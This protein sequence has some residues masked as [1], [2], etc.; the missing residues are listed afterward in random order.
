MDIKKA[1][2]KTWRHRIIKQLQNWGLTGNIIY[3]IKNFLNDRL[4]KVT[5]NGLYSNQYKLK[6]GIPQGSPFITTL[7]LV[8]I[9]NMIQQ[10]P[11]P[12]KISLYATD[13]NIWIR[14]K[15]LKY[16]E[17]I[18]QHC[19]HNLSIW[20]KSSSF[21][22]SPEKSKYNIFSNSKNI[23]KP[24]ITLGNKQIEYTKTMKIY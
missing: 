22:F 8:A 6:N 14:H 13:R 11:K 1:F 18:I 19:T 3:L 9:N 20:E 21:Y 17:S 4:F 2:N 23:I 16:I 5:I 15:S 10:I 7:F 12:A 24:N